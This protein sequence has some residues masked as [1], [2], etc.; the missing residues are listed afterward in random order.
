MLWLPSVRR[1]Q[2]RRT[3]TSSL[4]PPSGGRV[5]T[6]CT[7]QLPSASRIVQL[8]PPATRLASSLTS[9]QELEKQAR[10]DPAQRVGV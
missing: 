1:T 6:P 7:S 8:A 2:R 4:N 3:R 9:I 5:V 10:V